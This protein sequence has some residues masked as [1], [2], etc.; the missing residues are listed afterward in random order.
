MRD[1]AGRRTDFGRDRPPPDASRDRRRSEK[2][3]AL[4]PAR[5]AAVGPRG[6][7][8]RRGAK[9]RLP[10][11]RRR[12]GDRLQF[13]QFPAGRRARAPPKSKSAI[14]PPTSTAGPA[15]PAPAPPP[16]PAAI[17]AP[18]TAAVA[19]APQ[20]LERRGG[21]N[22]TGTGAGAGSALDSDGPL[23]AGLTPPRRRSGGS[24]RTRRHS[25]KSASRSAPSRRAR[26]SK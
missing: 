23:T 20:Y 22:Y 17:V 13:R 9:L 2:S 3:A 26:R 16:A 19:R 11:R 14:K 4:P 25:I 18:P 10:G 12:R 5:S 24:R 6:G 15:S 21:P 7:P 1:L 8:H